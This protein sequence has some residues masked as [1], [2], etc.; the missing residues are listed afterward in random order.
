MNPRRPWALLLLVALVF[1]TSACAPKRSVRRM[2]VTAYCDCRKCTNWER[3]SWK[4]LKLDFWNRYVNAGPDKGRRYSGRTASGTWPHEPQPGL[5]SL[6]TLTHPW[7]LPFRLVLPWLW[8]ARPGTV[9]ADTRYYPFGTR[10]HIPGYG[11]GVVEDRGGA[12]R[13]PSRLDVFYDSHQDARRYGR[14]H[15]NVQIWRARR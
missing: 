1:F 6:D 12:I 13:G 10:L 5:L 11:D 14:R 15:V 4:Y 3:G 8:R 9:A 7:M 2:E